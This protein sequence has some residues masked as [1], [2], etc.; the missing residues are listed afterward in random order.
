MS[1]HSAKTV[2]AY[3]YCDAGDGES[4]T[5]MVFAGHNIVSENGRTLIESDLFDNKL[6]FADVDLKYIVYEREKLFNSFPAGTTMPK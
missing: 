5:D 1:S 4:S 6:I 3:V 2:T